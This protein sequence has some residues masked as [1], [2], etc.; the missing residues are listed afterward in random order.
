MEK[1]KMNRRKQNLYLFFE[2]D[3]SNLDFIYSRLVSIYMNRYVIDEENQNEI[4]GVYKLLKDPREKTWPDWIN[5]VAKESFDGQMFDCAYND[6]KERVNTAHFIIGSSIGTKFHYGFSYHPLHY[7]E[8]WVQTKFKAHF[9]RSN[10]TWNEPMVFTLLLGQKE[11]IA[12]VADGLVKYAYFDDKSYFHPGKHCGRRHEDG[13]PHGFSVH[14]DLEDQTDLIQTN[15]EIS[16]W[17]HF[18]EYSTHRWLKNVLF[19]HR[20]LFLLKM[21]TDLEEAE[22]NKK[23]NSERYPLYNFYKCERFTMISYPDQAD[24]VIV[25]YWLDSKHFPRVSIIFH[26]RLLKQPSVE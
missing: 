26:D 1:Q 10:S 6:A 15:K 8:K 4:N 21:L 22:M 16:G 18:E 24:C 19:V 7:F 2:E 11:R 17:S 23:W 12:P 13:Y 5:R 3:D 9:T 20:K 14:N 25:N